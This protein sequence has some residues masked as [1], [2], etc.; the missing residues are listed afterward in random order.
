MNIEKVD[1]VYLIGIGGIGMSALARYFAGEEKAVAGYDRTSTDLTHALIKEGMSI[2]FSDEVAL[3]PEQFKV[4]EGTI[5]IYTPAVP[6]HH[7][8]LN[9]FRS[10]GFKVLK[11]SEVLGELSRGKRT[12]AV[13]G[14]HGKTTITTFVAHLLTAGGMGCGAFL[15]GISKN[16]GTNFLAGSGSQ[17]LI[18]E[19][20]EYDRSFLRLF[21]DYAVITSIDADHLDIYQTYEAITL[22]FSQFVAQVKAGG[23]VVIK[24]GV[25]VAIDRTDIAVYRYSLHQECD[26]Y[27]QSIR[28]ENGVSIFDLVTPQ[29]IISDLQLHLP[30]HVNMENAV[31][32]SALALLGGISAEELR[33]G[34]ASFKGV[35]RRFDIRFKQDDVVLVD[36]YAHHPV[37]LRAAISAMRESFPGK[38]VTGVF[39]P[40]LFTRTRDL[41]SDFAASLSLLDELYLLDIY[42]AREEP[43]VGVSSMLLLDMISISKKQLVSKEALVR[44]LAE[45]N[46]LEVVIMMGAGDIDKLVTPVQQMLEK[47]YSQ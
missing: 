17:N 23:A 5:V 6:T 39:Q 4:A 12:I 13:S 47:K 26:Y 45:R 21:P 33:V 19:A 32:A 24:M 30:G 7:L 29:G 1:R 14:T 38:H 35:R 36:D 2:H 25:S 20:D 42:P 8:E 31:A 28:L 3:I 9:W 43:I 11:R 22:A 46:D 16:Y 40:H 27:A 44:L 41:A 18:V 34:I 15:G 37:E 10:Q